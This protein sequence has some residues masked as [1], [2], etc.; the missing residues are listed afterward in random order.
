MLRLLEGRATE[1]HRAC[2]VPASRS[3]APRLVWDES[4]I[5]KETSAKHPRRSVNLAQGAA[6]VAVRSP[7]ALPPPPRACL[8]HA[9]V[10]AETP[11]VSPTEGPCRGRAAVGNFIASWNYFNST[12]L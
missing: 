3:C 11:V 2:P 9:A 10:G 8:K 6:A 1:A 5:V 4:A 12:G 7:A